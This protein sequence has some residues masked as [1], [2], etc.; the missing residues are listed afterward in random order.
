MLIGSMGGMGK[1]GKKK[2]VQKRAKTYRKFD[3]S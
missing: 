1:K 3:K 2:M